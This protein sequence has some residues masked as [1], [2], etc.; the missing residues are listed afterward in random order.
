MSAR[1]IRWCG[2][3]LSLGVLGLCA[4]ACTDDDAGER[5]GAAESGSSGT[6]AG[7]KGSAGKPS[8]SGGG[9]SGAKSQGGANQVGG[10]S[11]GGKS[12]AEAGSPSGGTGGGGGSSGVGGGMKSAGCGKPAPLAEATQ[13]SVTLGS[14]PRGYF[15]VPPTGYDSKTPYALVFA[16]HGAGGDGSGLRGYFGL[17]AA[18]KGQAIFVY[19]DG[20]G[21]IWDLKND[22]PDAKLFD[23]LLTTLEDAW[24]IDKGSVFTAGFSYGG[25]AAT[26]MAK[27]RPAV[28]RG[29]ASIAGGG[30][31]GGGS[32]DA[33][34]AAIIV[35]GSSD[36]AEPIAAGES[37]RDHFLATNGCGATSSDVAPA[38]C[39]T[40]AGCMTGKAVQW[41]QHA[42]GHEVP[43]FAP[44]GIWG[45]FASLR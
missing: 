16:F 28:V 12:S 35:H 38:P 15:L 41:C 30:P 20:L 8:M 34:V 17:E 4:Q 7:G 13:Q 3:V 19:P 32:K 9:A 45:F 25:W 36:G 14:D 22:G 11:N 21:G 18:S 1:V 29:V 5:P 40:Y 37:S 33:P 44:T 2:A 27:A 26:Q 6:A 42:G 39:K 43:A 23:A 10:E 31:Q 24:C